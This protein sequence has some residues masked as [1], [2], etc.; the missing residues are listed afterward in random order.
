M[1]RV[2]ASDCDGTLIRGDAG[3]QG[4]PMGIALPLA[5]LG[6]LIPPWSMVAVAAAQLRRDS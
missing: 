4:G 6:R 2:V 3:Q 1:N 5:V